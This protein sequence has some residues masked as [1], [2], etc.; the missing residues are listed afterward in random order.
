MGNGGR[1]L[2]KKTVKKTHK[3]LK[4]TLIVLAVI[5]VLLIALLI[6]GYLYVRYLTGFVSNDLPPVET[7]APML[8][9]TDSTQGTD[10]EEIIQTEPSVPETTSPL[11]TWPEIV[12]NQNVTNIMLVG[13][14][15]RH[16]ETSKLADTMILCSINRETKTLTMTSFLRDC[17]VT[18]PAYAGHTQGGNR[19]NV[20]YNLG[21]RW[22][23]ENS[24]GGMEMLALCIEQ[25]FGIPVHHTV[26]IDFLSFAKIIDI[27]GGV[28]IELTQ[29]EA[30]F[31]T[32]QKYFGEVQPGPQTLDGYL[33][34]AYA[35][36][37]SI[38]SD[39]NRTNRQRTVITSLIN[40]FRSMNLLDLHKLATEVL[41]LIITDMTTDEINNYIWEFLPML[42]DLNIVSQSVPMDKETLGQW[43][44]KG[45]FK[46]GIGQV[47]EL[48][49]W[50]HKQFLQQQLG[51]SDAE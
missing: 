47:L 13:Q 30:D 6:G 42:A 1:Y 46:E 17:Y 5:A 29:E 19:I 7:T 15:F 11:E 48:N 24:R 37:R 50:G 33:A 20:V 35:R 12:S 26:E 43:S 3:G 9:A 41:P 51:F 44:Y 10:N 4:I 8:A 18:I 21:W 28:D 39:F 45:V 25:N 22:T 31:L 38:D 23:G 14:N 36:I 2:N 32:L 49:L 40:K 34:L 27:L 16:D